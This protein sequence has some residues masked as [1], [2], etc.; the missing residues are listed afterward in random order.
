M[1]AQ[2]PKSNLLTTAEGA[3]AELIKENETLTTFLFAFHSFDTVC[4]ASTKLCVY[5]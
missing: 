3:G 5:L 1:C 2:K 4:S